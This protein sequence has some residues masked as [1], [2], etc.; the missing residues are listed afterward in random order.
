MKKMK[1]GEKKKEEQ[2]SAFIL[3][4]F[5]VGIQKKKTCISH[6]LIPSS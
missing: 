4:C 3:F 2:L 5:F 1:K 6:F